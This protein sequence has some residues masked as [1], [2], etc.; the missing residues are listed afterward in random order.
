MNENFYLTL[1][2]NSSMKYFSKNVTSNFTTQ[3]PKSINLEGE[4][5]VALSEIQFP[6]SFLT[7]LAH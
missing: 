3:L 6:C 7:I 4:W 5:N 1:L 2:S